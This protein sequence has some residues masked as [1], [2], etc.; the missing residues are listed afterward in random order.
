MDGP[1]AS[2]ATS[3][4]EPLRTINPIGPSGDVAETAESREDRSP[5]VP[6][7][8]SANRSVHN[9]SDTHVDEGAGTLRLGTSGDPSGR[10]ITSVNTKVVRTSQSHQSAYHSLVATRSA[11][12]TRSIHQGNVAKGELSRR[13]SFMCIIGLS[14]RD[15]DLIL[16]RGVGSSLST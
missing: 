11:S 13:G 16:P 14:I 4:L 6:L 5:R 3:S 15:V 10:A 8:G 1:V 12:P 7:H 2:E 9:Y